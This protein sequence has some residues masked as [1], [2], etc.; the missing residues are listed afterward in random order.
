MSEKLLQANFVSVAEDL[1][2]TTKVP[3][4]ATVQVSVSPA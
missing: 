3:L 2:I 4:G 1:L